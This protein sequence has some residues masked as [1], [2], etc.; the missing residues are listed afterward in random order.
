MQPERLP[1]WWPRLAIQTDTPTQRGG[2]LLNVIQVADALNCGRTLVYQLIATGELPVV[3]LGKLT[4]IPAEALE[5]FVRSRTS[6]KE[7]RPW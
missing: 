2:L 3:K 7:Q 1:Q 6:A 5:D 4:R